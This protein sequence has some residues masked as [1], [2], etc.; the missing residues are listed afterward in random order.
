MS[1]VDFNDQW[2][3]E[4]DGIRAFSKDGE[5]EI[6]VFA[7]PELS[8]PYA[9]SIAHQQ[10]DVLAVPVWVHQWDEGFPDILSGQVAAMKQVN[11]LALHPEELIRVK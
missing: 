6:Q 8:D 11:Y 3:V 9:A 7:T 1:K 4:A 10:L 2:I 5:W